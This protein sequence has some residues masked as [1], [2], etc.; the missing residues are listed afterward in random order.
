MKYHE[1]VGAP[2]GNTAKS[3]WVTPPS[4]SNEDLAPE[5]PENLEAAAGQPRAPEGEEGGKA[6]GEERGQ[7]ADVAAEVLMKV[8]YAARMARPD[9]LAPV[10]ALSRFVTKWTRDCDRRLARLMQYIRYSQHWKQVAHVGDDAQSLKIVLFADADFAG[11]AETA[12]STTGVFLA[13]MGANT[14][15]PVAAMSKRQGC[16]SHSTTEAELV[17][18]DTALRLFGLPMQTLLQPLLTD[19]G[20]AF[21]ARDGDDTVGARA[22]H[23]V[24]FAEDNQA[25]IRVCRSGRSPSLR[26]LARTHR[27]SLSWLYEVFQRGDVKLGYIVTTSQAADIFTKPIANATKWEAACRLLGVVR[28][29]GEA[30]GR[31]VISECY[32]ELEKSHEEG[33]FAAVPTGHGARLTPG[34]NPAKGDQG[35]EGRKGDER[36]KRC[37]S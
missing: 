16:V 9:L 20:G 37:C 21:G 7:L 31:E 12:R 6:D 23:Q 17:A 24:W 2:G 27:V 4:G 26:H 34:A 14:F 33:G 3:P 25:T 8:L 5:P 30:E 13:I 10:S 28:R 36:T 32:V 15:V 11:C 35:A 19:D 18:M 22:Y 1:L 29:G